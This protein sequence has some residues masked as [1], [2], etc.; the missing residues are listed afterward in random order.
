MVDIWVNGL[1][2]GFS[3]VMGVP[4]LGYMVDV[5]ENLKDEMDEN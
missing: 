5:M 1:F 2:N 3:T 4:Q